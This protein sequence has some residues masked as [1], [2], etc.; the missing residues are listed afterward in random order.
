M[1]DI[2]FTVTR[3]WPGNENQKKVG[4]HATFN[5]TINGPDG[6]IASIN[7]MKLLTTKEG[8]YYVE[9]ASRQYPDKEGNNKRI[10]YVKFFPEK[11]NWHMQ[12][13]IVNLVV[14]ALK[15]NSPTGAKP[16]AN[17]ASKPKTVATKPAPSDNEDW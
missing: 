3:A 17:T 13:S 16:A 1:S 12:E 2:T 14:D 5:I 10:H 15:Q 8:K 11:Q 6:I 9:S 7:D 4:I